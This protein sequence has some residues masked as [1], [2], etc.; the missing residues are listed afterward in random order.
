VQSSAEKATVARV[1]RR[2]YGVTAVTDELGER[3]PSD[4]DRADTDIAPAILAALKWNTTV[5]VATGVL[6]LKGTC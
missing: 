5:D 2:H 4:N 3:L 1:A 6:T